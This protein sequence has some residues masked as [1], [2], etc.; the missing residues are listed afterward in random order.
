MSDRHFKEDYV[1][2]GTLFSVAQKGYGGLEDFTSLVDGSIE[3]YRDNYSAG[4]ALFVYL[5]SWT[6][7][8][9]GGTPIFQSQLEAYQKDRNRS[10]GG[11]AKG[12]AAYF[13]DG[14]HGRPESLEDFAK[15]YDRFLRGFYWKEMEPWTTR[16][17]PGAPAGE[18]AS[19]VMDEPTSTWL[20]VLMGRGVLIWPRLQMRKRLS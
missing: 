12:F 14:K 5:R 1:S 17:D 2:F 4:Y 15:D 11:G 20:R 13:A 7:F 8:E 6:G 18:S 16:Y 9:E 10:R 3:E 19:R